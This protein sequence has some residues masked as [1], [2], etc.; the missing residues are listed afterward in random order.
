M[1]GKTKRFWPSYKKGRRRRSTKKSEFEK[2]ARRSK[3]CTRENKRMKRQGKIQKIL[4]ELKETGNILSTKSVKKWIL[5]PKVKNKK[6]ETINT[7]QGIANV[8]DEIYESLY[9]GEEDDEEWELSR[10]LKKMKDYLTNTTPF[11]NLQK[12]MR[13]KMQ[14]TTSKKRKAKDSSGVRAEQ[15]KNCSDNTKEKSGRSS[16]KLHDRKTSNRKVGA[17]SE[18]RSCTKK[19]DKEDAGKL[20]ANVQPASTIETICLST[21]C[22]SRSISAQNTTSRPRCVSAQSSCWWSS[23]G[24]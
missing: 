13:S 17:R 8:F 6:G 12:K 5:F 23:D 10:A 1:E 22:T 19:S 16:M 2:S 18:S 11:Q 21:I 3:K 20:H 15:L 14:S 9:E 7:R 4:E 24:V